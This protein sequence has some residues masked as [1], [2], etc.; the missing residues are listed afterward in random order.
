[1][2]VRVRH[3]RGAW[4]VFIS[5][6]G[7][8]KA[9]KVGD[10]VAAESVARAIRERLARADL[11]LPVSATETFHTYTAA[12]LKAALGN[13]KASTL[14]FSGTSGPTY[15]SGVGEPFRIKPASG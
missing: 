14:G 1:M 5:H 7:R 11:H 4:W 3:Y 8:R 2:G 9:K 10:R 12:W 6:H 15:P 13:L